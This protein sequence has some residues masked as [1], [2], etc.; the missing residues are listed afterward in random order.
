ML[1]F[2]ATQVEFCGVTSCTMKIVGER[3]EV[4]GGSA[5]AIENDRRHSE[6]S[7]EKL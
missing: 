6:F 1:V 5:M 4:T 2:E 3:E 7:H